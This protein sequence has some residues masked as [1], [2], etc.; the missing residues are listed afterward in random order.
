M[1]EISNLLVDMGTGGVI[2]AVVGYAS[3]IILKILLVFIGLYFG[4]LVYLSKKGVISFN[5]EAFESLLN[6]TS[7]AAAGYAGS[8]LNTALAVAP[9]GGGFVAGFYLGFKKA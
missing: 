1:I 4:S 3:K 9:F 8:L 6:S 7:S 2:G 5:Q